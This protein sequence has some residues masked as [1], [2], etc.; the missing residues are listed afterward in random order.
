MNILKKVL[1][2]VDQS[3]NIRPVFENRIS[4]GSNVYQDQK[5]SRR[6]REIRTVEELSQRSWFWK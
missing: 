6:T 3:R 2:T 5:P 1:K 4:K